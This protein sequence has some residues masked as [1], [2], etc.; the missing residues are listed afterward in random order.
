MVDEP[1]KEPGLRA[2]VYAELPANATP[3][4]TACHAIHRH[5]L[6]N[7]Q[8]DIVTLI[9]EKM[10]AN[11]GD[12]PH[13]IITITDGDLD[14]RTDGDLLGLLEQTAGGVLVFGVSYTEDT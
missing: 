13:I 11:Y 7:A 6:D 8:G 4:D 9:R 2:L 1:P 5:T 3:T 12:E 10:S 14:P